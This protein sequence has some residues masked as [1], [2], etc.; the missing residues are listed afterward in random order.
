MIGMLSPLN[1][2]RKSIYQTGELQTGKRQPEEQI[3]NSNHLAI[4]EF[5]TLKSS[6]KLKL[7]PMS[8]NYCIMSYRHLMSVAQRNV[9]INQVPS[10]ILQ[11]CIGQ[12]QK[13]V[14]AGSM[15]LRR[16]VDAVLHSAQYLSSTKYFPLTELRR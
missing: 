13:Y 9:Q 3:L 6:F 16:E 8:T 11:F 4:N 10:T 1:G 14:A 2:T 5:Q 15:Q 7:Y 12:R